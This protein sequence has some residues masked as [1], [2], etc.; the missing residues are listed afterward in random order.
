VTLSLTSRTICSLRHAYNSVILVGV[1]AI[2]GIWW[3]VHAVNNY[4]GPR[5]MHVYIHDDSVSGTGTGTGTS[6]GP[7]GNGVVVIGDKAL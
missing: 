3:A 4:P 1:V 5:V 6:T 7:S 2:S